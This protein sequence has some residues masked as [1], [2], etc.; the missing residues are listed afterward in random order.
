VPVRGTTAW[1][2]ARLERKVIVNEGRHEATGTRIFCAWDDCDRD[3]Y[4][5]YKLVVNYAKSGFPPYR[6]TYAF[7]SERHLLFFEN[8][9]RNFGRLPAG[10][11]RSLL[12]GR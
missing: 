11:R 12:P 8:A 5:L 1:H 9:A 3:A 7:C 6:T 2:H 4:D 10:T